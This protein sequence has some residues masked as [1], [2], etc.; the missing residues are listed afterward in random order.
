MKR[1]LSIILISVICLSFA[2]CSS[3]GNHQS[4]SER[5]EASIEQ[6]TTIQATTAEISTDI[7]SPT[8]IDVVGMTRETATSA[9]ESRGFT[10]KIKEEYS[11]SV[12]KGY[13]IKQLPRI[14]NNITYNQGD[15]VTLTVSLGKDDKKQYLCQMLYSNEKTDIK[16]NNFSIY[17]GEDY[18]QDRCRN[19]LKFTFV[20]NQDQYPDEISRTHYATYSISYD[21]DSK[22]S[23]FISELT[24]K[25]VY[26]NFNIEILGD[27]KILFKQGITEDTEKLDL[28]LDVKNVKIFTIKYEGFLNWDVYS[29]DSEIIFNEAYFK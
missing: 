11:D 28:D 5:I 26:D 16:R 20:H 25:G 27:D 17:D 19:A 29:Y 6:P 12:D 2:A 9:L 3:N 15:S 10:V 8:L 14:E 7:E 23:S 21:I 13:V 24:H 18:N 22:F 1:I 4:I